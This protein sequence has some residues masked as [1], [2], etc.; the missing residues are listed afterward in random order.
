MSIQIESAN[1]LAS[2][3]LFVDYLKNR[4]CQD[5]SLLLVSEAS[6]RLSQSH[7]SRL[8]SFSSE[9]REDKDLGEGR[10]WR[11][12]TIALLCRRVAMNCTAAAG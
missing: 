11:V 5:V 10:C 7:H 12:A 3:Q 2:T 9:D 4:N 8:A 6:V 1:R